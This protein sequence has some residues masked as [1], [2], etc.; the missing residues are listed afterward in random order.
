MIRYSCQLDFL[1]QHALGQCQCGP[2]PALEM[3]C[4]VCTPWPWTMCISCPLCRH[5][6][7]LVPDARGRH[8]K[9][10][11]VAQ[12]DMHTFLRTLQDGKG[13]GDFTCASHSF[14]DDLGVPCVPDTGGPQQQA[15]Q[16]EQ[17]WGRQETDWQTGLEVRRA[18][19]DCRAEEGGVTQQRTG[20]AERQD[21]GLGRVEA[22]LE[23]S[24]RQ[25]QRGERGHAGWGAS[26][27]CVPGGLGWYGH[28]AVWLPS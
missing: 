22:K 28:R 23:E 10:L 16:A 25:G 21:R 19:E 13:S 17:P 12:V 3:V 24:V 9:C 15:R 18:K 14:S 4:S 26:W 2:D 27:G 7:R 11:P 6:A 8:T 5:S 20:S 1:S